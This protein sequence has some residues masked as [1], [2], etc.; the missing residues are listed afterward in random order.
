[1]LAATVNPRRWMRF[2]LARATREAQNPH[3]RPRRAAPASHLPLRICSSSSS[4][5]QPSRTLPHPRPYIPFAA[6]CDSSSRLAS[7][8]ASVRSYGPRWVAVLL[9]APRVVVSQ[10]ALPCLLFLHPQSLPLCSRTGP[11][12]HAHARGSLSLR[13]T[14]WNVSACQMCQRCCLVQ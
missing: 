9:L 10:R 6:L 5:L 14:V 13:P 3:P 7:R 1:M 4:I 2:P 8:L 12:W 11:Y